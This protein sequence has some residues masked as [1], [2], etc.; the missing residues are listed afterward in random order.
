MHFSS[1]GADELFVGGRGA[2]LEQP[3]VTAELSDWSMS[4]RQQARAS[5]ALTPLYRADSDA[6]NI[7]FHRYPPTDFAVG[8]RLLSQR[9]PRAA[10]VA[11][12]LF[13]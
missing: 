2:S 8:G 3:D 12:G 6:V 13:G 10:R 1:Y 5:L 11:K 7:R 4:T 9:V